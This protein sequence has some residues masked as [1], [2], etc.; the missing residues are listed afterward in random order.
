MSSRAMSLK[1]KINN[2]AKQNKIAAQVVLQNYMF[3]RF[4][5]RLAKSEYSQKFIIKGGML[6]AAIVGLDIRATMDLDTTIRNMKLSKENILQVVTDISN[7]D[8][9]DDIHFVVN[10]LALIR[11][12]DIYGGYRARLDAV[13][14]SIIT[15]L[16]VDISTGD[17]ITPKPVEYEFTGLF[18]E[19]AQIKLWCYNIETVLAEKAETILSR[20]IFN[21]RPRDFYDIYILSTTQRY[22]RE[23]FFEALVATA[24]NRGS[25]KRMGAAN[26]I[27]SALLAS[28][29]LRN[30]WE[31]YQRTF[32]YAKKISYVDTIN[33]LRK[34][35]N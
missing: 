28:E 13:F 6:I 29:G 27:C 20:G 2:Y 19:N 31:K 34:M 4:L 10:N 15:P 22:D 8:L 33:A 11:K 26:A 35:F 18:D 3:E 16:S 30:A 17:I 24:A 25:T 12:D 23:I 14:D 7:I 32:P 1:S 21:T 9:D 5:A